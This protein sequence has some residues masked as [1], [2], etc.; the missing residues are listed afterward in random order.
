MLIQPPEDHIKIDLHPIYSRL[1]IGQRKYLRENQFI[2][3]NC[4]NSYMTDGNLSVHNDIIELDNKE[5][6]DVCLDYFKDPC[7]TSAIVEY[8]DMG[9]MKTIINE[10][11]DQS[12]YNQ[13]QRIHIR[14]FKK[15]AEELPIDV[16]YMTLSDI[17]SGCLSAAKAISTVNYWIGPISPWFRFNLFKHLIFLECRT[18]LAYKLGALSAIHFKAW[19]KEPISLKGVP[20]KTCNDFDFSKWQQYESTSYV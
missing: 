6:D 16:D 19:R 1:K 20:L 10:C 8:I 13:L 12:D 11:Y 3:F 2:L 15:A 18:N 7:V 14:E 17:W 4:Y 5:K 9:A